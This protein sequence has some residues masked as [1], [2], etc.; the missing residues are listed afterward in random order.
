[1]GDNTCV[2]CNTFGELLLHIYMYMPQKCSGVYLKISLVITL[3]NGCVCVMFC[4]VKYAVFMYTVAIIGD[5]PQYVYIH[6]YITKTHH[7]FM[8][9]HVPICMG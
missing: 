9:V 6:F 4:G 3:Y 7:T 5:V 8:Q 1:M 2:I